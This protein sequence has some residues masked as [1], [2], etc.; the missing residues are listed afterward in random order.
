M[1][2]TKK[3]RIN[4]MTGGGLTELTKAKIEAALEGKPV[5]EEDLAETVVTGINLPADEEGEYRHGDIDITLEDLKLDKVE[6]KSVE[7]I[8]DEVRD[9]IDPEDINAVEKFA[10]EDSRDF[11]LI[12]ASQ[13]TDGET[14]AYGLVEGLEELQNF[15]NEEDDY[16]DDHPTWSEMNIVLEGSLIEFLKSD[17]YIEYIEGELGTGSGLVT[18]VKGSA[19]DSYRQGQVEITAANIGLGNVENKSAATILGELTQAQ[20]ETKLGLEL[21][22]DE[23]LQDVLDELEAGVAAAAVATEVESTY[24]KKTDVASAVR[25]KG[26]VSTADDLEELE[27]TAALGDLYNVEEDGMNYV[28]NGTEFDAF[29]PHID[30][31]GYETTANVNSKLALKADKSDLEDYTTTED[32]TDLLEAKADAEDLSDLEETVTGLSTSKLDKT[33]AENTYAKK[34]DIASVFR[35]KGTVDSADDLTALEATAATGDVYTAEDTDINYV[36]NGDEFIQFAPNVDLSGKL[37]VTALTK[38]LIE[39]KLGATDI[40]TTLTSLSTN[41]MDKS[42][43][44]QANIEEAL[45]LD[46]EDDE[47]EATS[48][49]EKIAALEANIQSATD[50]LTKEA[51]EAKLGF[52]WSEDE[53]NEENG[54]TDLK[55]KIEYMDE[56]ISAKLDASAVTAAFIK[57]VLGYTPENGDD[58]FTDYTFL[59]S[60]WTAETKGGT[61]Q[62]KDDPTGNYL[63]T[64][65]KTDMGVETLTGEEYYEITQSQN[66]P[67]EQLIALGELFLNGVSQDENGFTIRAIKKP[68]IDIKL[69][70][71]IDY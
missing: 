48:L 7:E 41:K 23:H 38:D 22:A 11:D 56:L 19:E 53:D 61:G 1:A 45:G 49:A 20:V 4:I 25:W 35:Y 67:T 43:F 62:D 57:S 27:D 34:T 3:G 26:S 18:G 69:T 63:Y 31:S 66:M 17:E 42:D 24:A 10:V 32:L 28:W 46:W 2:E 51:I 70:I 37:D 52:D 58:Y 13:G 68:A 55:S 40:A 54:I 50:S 44:T 71:K 15:F 14:I 16:E 60:K 64:V 65:T 30:L 9:A 29:A 36:F 59:V 6:N 12:Y 8:I 33:E 47:D 5:L 39:T 21:D